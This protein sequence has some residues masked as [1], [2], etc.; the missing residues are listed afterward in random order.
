[1]PILAE[2]S[3]WIYTERYKW[4]SRAKQELVKQ[5]SHP[6]TRDMILSNNGK[7]V[8]LALF[9]KT[10]VGKTTLI[11][12]IMRVKKERMY[13]LN[14]ILRCGSA[15]GDSATPTAMIYKVS[16]DNQFRIHNPSSNKDSTTA[17]NSKQA[18]KELKRI[19]SD[20]ESN[21]LC[22]LNEWIIEIPYDYFDE[23]PVEL[24]IIDLP[25]L[26]SKNK[27]EEEF[28][29]K[30]IKQFLPAANIVLVIDRGNQ[31]TGFLNLFEDEEI[32]RLTNW[33][34]FPEKYRIITTYTYSA[35]SINR[36]YKDNPETSPESIRELYKS[37]INRT[38]GNDDCKD[39]IL[40]PLEYGD[41]WDSFCNEH[42][43]ETYLG[44]VKQ[45]NSR[46]F[47]SLIDDISKASTEINQITMLG[48]ISLAL[49]KRKLDTEGELEELIEKQ[50]QLIE[51]Q[52]R[53]I[54]KYLDVV[55]GNRDLF[56]QIRML[57]EKIQEIGFDKSEISHY[58]GD[59][60]KDEF[61][62]AADDVSNKMKQKIHDWSDSLT[63]TMNEFPN[64]FQTSFFN[65]ASGSVQQILDS[66]A[67]KVTI[68][69]DKQ[70]EETRRYIRKTLSGSAL[71]ENRW[72]K[73]TRSLLNS[74]IDSINKLIKTLH[75]LTIMPHMKK[76]LI[77]DL[78]LKQE[79]L[80]VI[81]KD[82]EQKQKEV[83]RLHTEE[84]KQVDE[85][86]VTY[87]K[88]IKLL[89][90]DIKESSY[91]SKAI[92]KAVSYTI[93]EYIAVANKSEGSNVLK[94][95]LFARQTLNDYRA[96]IQL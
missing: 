59:W 96:S 28:T 54:Q 51:K 35:D 64:A 43:D 21:S 71:K 36:L 33:K 50:Y 53:E 95:V 77:E 88:S 68:M 41:S 81:I 70:L 76:H 16:P 45:T 37:E 2:W 24:N 85:Q 23:N 80:S 1:M 82:T 74:S 92:E 6:F 5:I 47:E 10:Q 72:Q 25:G 62:I 87:N 60:G 83:E 78:E 58:M 15:K 61:L 19:R 84:R 8:N 67:E 30:L 31:L 49:E 13:E 14:T 79:N 22:E 89:E 32:N 66:L 65:D 55:K 52:Q 44:K 27:Y 40:Y 42:K 90:T 94:N 9:G 39:L 12:Q 57:C 20:V 91:L 29:K 56:D 48:K 38:L 11:M 3:N 18:E 75:E 93:G 4:V 73:E 17:L 69:V 7:K 46:F 63:Y 34:Y 86:I 26:D